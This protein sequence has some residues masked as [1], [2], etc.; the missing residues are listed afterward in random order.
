MNKIEAIRSK[1]SLIP[2]VHKI[3]NLPEVKELISE[4][5][6]IIVTEAIRIVQSELRDSLKENN[7]S[8]VDLKNINVFISR[9]K[10]KIEEIT[11]DTLFPVLNLSGTVLHTNLG[12]ASL[13]DEAIKSLSLIARGPSNL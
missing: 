4:K 5:G 3:L 12:R 1:F 10:N 13:P 2:S 7:K 6:K 8:F 9:L 11:K